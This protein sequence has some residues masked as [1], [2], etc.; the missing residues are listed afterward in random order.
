VNVYKGDEGKRI[1]QTPTYPFV[2]KRFR[3]RK[4]R[5]REKEGERKS[6]QSL[7]SFEIGEGAEKR[8]KESVRERD[9]G[10]AHSHR[11]H[12]RHYKKGPIPKQV[13]RKKKTLNRLVFPHQVSWQP[14]F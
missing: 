12:H 6:E 14:A 2:Q 5:K 8:R 10:C 9:L 4:R 3:A 13:K 11:N 7:N 1:F